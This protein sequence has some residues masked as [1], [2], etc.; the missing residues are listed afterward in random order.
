MFIVL[1]IVEQEGYDTSVEK[2]LS[3][4][5][6]SFE[7]LLEPLKLKVRMRNTVKV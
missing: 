7:A 5:K 1:I 6:Q 2:L 3:Y 4:L